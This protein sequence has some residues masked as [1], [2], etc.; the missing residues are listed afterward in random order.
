MLNCPY[1]L[2]NFTIFCLPVVFFFFDKMERHTKNPPNTD[3][4]YA[5]FFVK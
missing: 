1:F 4:W 2:A 5:H 3:G